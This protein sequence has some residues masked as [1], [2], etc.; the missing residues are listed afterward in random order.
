VAATT[1]G[2]APLNELLFRYR[3]QFFD[4][5]PDSILAHLLKRFPSSTVNMIP[6][7]VSRRLGFREAT[8]ATKQERSS[9]RCIQSGCPSWIGL[10]D[11]VVSVRRDTVCDVS[12]FDHVFRRKS[13]KRV[14]CGGD[15]RL[16]RDPAAFGHIDWTKEVWAKD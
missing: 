8:P 6:H 3:L 4:A 16:P 11:F 10:S 1:A 13:S 5:P 9:S 7:L 12:V 2:P 14:Q 15:A